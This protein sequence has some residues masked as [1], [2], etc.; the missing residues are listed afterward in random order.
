MQSAQQVSRPHR[1]ADSAVRVHA[2]ILH[3]HVLQA[4]QASGKA[5]PGRSARLVIVT[6]SACRGRSARCTG[7]RGAAAAAPA[8][9]GAALLGDSREVSTALTLL[10]QRYLRSELRVLLSVDGQN[11]ASRG[12]CE[13]RARPRN[14]RLSLAFYLLKS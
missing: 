9:T 5:R 2:C 4:G 3:L 7:V 12:C 10:T 8:P 11:G 13:E 1:C 6:T 14:E